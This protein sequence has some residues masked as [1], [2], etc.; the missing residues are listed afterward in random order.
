MQP[1]ITKAEETILLDAAKN[2]DLAVIQEYSCLHRQQQQ[3]Q[4]HPPSSLLASITDSS[5]CTM[6]HWAAGN[7]HE[8]TLRHLLTIFHPDTQVKS[9]Q[10]FGRTALQ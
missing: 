3:Q 9:K 5:G 8:A 2:G 4:H 1:K 6:L 10:A 7:N